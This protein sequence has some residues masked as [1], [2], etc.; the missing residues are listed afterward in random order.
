MENSRANALFKLVAS[1]S[2]DLHVQVF[3]KIVEEPSISKPPPMLQVNV[4]PY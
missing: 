1:T 2:C 4:E 3:F